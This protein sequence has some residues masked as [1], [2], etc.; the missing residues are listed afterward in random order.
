MKKLFFTLA[1]AL[2]VATTASAQDAG[3]Y[4][5]GGAVG[6]GSTKVNDGDRST[7]F[8]VLPEFGY[9]LSENLGVGVSIGGGH[10]NIGL[11]D[12]GAKVSHEQNFYKVSP[13]LRYTFLKGDIGGLFVDAGFGYSWSKLVAGGA[14]GHRWEAGIKPGVALN[15]SSKVA[16][17]GKFGFLGYEYDKYSKDSKTDSFG[18]N[19]DM[20]N[21]EFG[22]NFRF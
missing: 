16:L 4:W 15:V 14:H 3:Q 5:V 11:T 8:Q 7:D 18:F 2:G 10:R 21:V 19:F 20:N 1:I 22:V 9:I 6:F 17:L 12:G 13:F